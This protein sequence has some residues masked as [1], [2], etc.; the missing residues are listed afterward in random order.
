MEEVAGL[1]PV[2]CM[3]ESFLAFSLCLWPP[4]GHISV[5]D[6]DIMPAFKTGMRGKGERSCWTFIPCYGDSKLT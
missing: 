5:K 6:R 2:E 3:P 4:G 1:N